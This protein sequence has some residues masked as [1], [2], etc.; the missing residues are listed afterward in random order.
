[1]K[2]RGWVAARHQ[3]A[4]YRFRRFD[5]AA[6]VFGGA[7]A[8]L[9]AAAAWAACAQFRFYPTSAGCALVE[10]LPYA[11]FACLP[12]AITEGASAMAS[13]K[14]IEARG[15]SFRYPESTAGIGARL[16]GGGGQLLCF[17]AAA[18]HAAR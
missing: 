2:A 9:A 4:R 6:L 14:A 18:D 1:M 7:L 10:L 16:G 11:L 17:T 5:A 13:V 15:F 12:L 3:Y 8:L